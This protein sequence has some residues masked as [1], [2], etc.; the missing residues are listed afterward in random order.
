M[1]YLC[2]EVHNVE[3]LTKY[4]PVDT[5]EAFF[6]HPWVSICGGVLGSAQSQWQ[7][8]LDCGWVGDEDMGKFRGIFCD[9][10]IDEVE[11]REIETHIV[12]KAEPYLSCARGNSL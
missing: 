10:P 2:N 3:T 6:A 12:D 11:I 4:H 5:C 9:T 7:L 1:Y 8:L